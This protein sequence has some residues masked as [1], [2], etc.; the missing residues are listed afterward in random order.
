MCIKLNNGKFLQFVF[1]FLILFGYG[2][3]S[4]HSQSDVSTVSGSGETA[5]ADDFYANLPSGARAKCRTSGSLRDLLD[6]TRFFKSLQN[7][8]LTDQENKQFAVRERVVDDKVDTDMFLK[9]S[10]VTRDDLVNLLLLKKLVATRTALANLSIIVKSQEATSL[11]KLNQ[12]TGAT[13]NEVVYIAQDKDADG[14]NVVSTIFVKIDKI[15]NKT[16]S[17]GEKF[18]VADGSMKLILALPPKKK[19]PSGELVDVVSADP[20]VIACEF[21]DCPVL[22]TNVEEQLKNFFGEDVSG[23]FSEGRSSD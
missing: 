22:N 16:N 9:I 17:K 10:D 7:A 14:N 13:G 15:T 12:T 5:T 20:G 6:G 8:I 2:I 21:K 18:A 19:L 1:I 4:V 23:L 3:L 11:R